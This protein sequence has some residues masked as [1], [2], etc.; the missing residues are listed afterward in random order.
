MLGTAKGA[1]MSCHMGF[2][3]KSNDM[4]LRPHNRHGRNGSYNRE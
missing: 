2:D 3:V 1:S 4:A